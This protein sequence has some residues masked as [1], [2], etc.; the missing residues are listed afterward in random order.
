[1]MKH[2]SSLEIEDVATYLSEKPSIA[3]QEEQ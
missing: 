2:D 3:Q 1:M